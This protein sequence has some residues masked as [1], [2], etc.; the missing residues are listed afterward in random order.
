MRYASLFAWIAILLFVA[1]FLATGQ[2]AGQGVL[3]SHD[4]RPVASARLQ[5]RGVGGRY[6]A[7]TKHDGTFVLK[8]P[9]DPA[10]ADG[11]YQVTVPGS[12]KSQVGSGCRP[13][14][15]LPG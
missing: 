8:G 11:D 14:G 12:A 9:D 1:P 5:F 13:P 3:Q 6:V 10:L 2:A 4:G 7:I 15:N